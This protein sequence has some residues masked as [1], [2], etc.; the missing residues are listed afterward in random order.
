MHLKNANFSRYV[1]T[2]ALSEELIFINPSSSAHVA[3]RHYL[4]DSGVVTTSGLQTGASGTAKKRRRSR[5]KQSTD[6]EAEKEASVADEMPIVI[7]LAPS[8]VANIQSSW[9]FIE[10]ILL[11]VSKTYIL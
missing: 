10:S 2:S 7:Q 3:F 1:R 5:R 6:L 8:D 9:V 11:K 4:E